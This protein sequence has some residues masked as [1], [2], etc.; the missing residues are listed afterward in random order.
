MNEVVRLALGKPIS[1]GSTNG[2]GTSEMHD[3]LEAQHTKL[4][5]ADQAK[6]GTIIISPTVGSNHGHVGIVGATTG[7]VGATQIF[8][9]SSSGRKFAQNY[10]IAKWN[11]R[12][13]NSKHLEVLFYQLNKDQF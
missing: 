8:S 9:N 6:P 7:S 13:I 12:F 1:G 4:S 2:L 11:A 3:V 10:T 5:G